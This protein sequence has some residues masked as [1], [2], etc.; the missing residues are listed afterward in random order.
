MH[1]DNMFKRSTVLKLVLAAIAFTCIA[2]VASYLSATRASD[3][4]V[5]RQFPEY[6]ANGELL[7]S[8]KWGTRAFVG[9]PLTPN[10]LY[11]M[12]VAFT[13][14]HNGY[15]KPASYTLDKETANSPKAQCFSNHL[16]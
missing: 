9:A 6:A 3:T 4:L 13:E 16:S 1:E 5:A 10:A 2:V 12:K 8:K 15:M 7:L 14:Y 11:G